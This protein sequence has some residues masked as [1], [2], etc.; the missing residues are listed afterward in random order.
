MEEL[1]M[2]SVLLYISIRNKQHNYTGAR[3]KKFDLGI[4]N[5]DSKC[6]ESIIQKFLIHILQRKSG[7][8]SKLKN[9]VI[10]I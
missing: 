1:C 2:S 5:N 6:T 3:E 7:P 10:G 9:Y 8:G 4:C